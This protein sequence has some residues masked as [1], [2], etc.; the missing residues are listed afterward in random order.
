MFNTSMN[1]KNQIIDNNQTIISKIYTQSGGNNNGIKDNTAYTAY[2]TYTAYTKNRN[3][4]EK[5]KAQ[6]NNQIKNN[7]IIGGNIS[8]IFLES[9]N[10]ARYEKENY[11]ELQKNMIDQ[12][13]DAMII[14]GGSKGKNKQTELHKDFTKRIKEGNKHMKK[15]YKLHD[16]VK[17]HF[18]KKIPVIKNNLVKM[19]QDISATI[20]TTLLLDIQRIAKMV[21]KQ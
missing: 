15:L 13:K 6:L 12:Q 5:L 18:S 10:T 11:K 7:R 14:D 20:R 16:K 3:Q 2:T 19:P 4:Y 1:K 9:Q 21:N 17:K 8:N